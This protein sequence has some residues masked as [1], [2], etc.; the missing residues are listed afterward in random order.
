MSKKVGWNWIP[1]TASLEFFDEF[2]LEHLIK[3]TRGPRRKISDFKVTNCVGNLNLN[4][5]MVS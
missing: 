5:I 3:G 1:T 4:Q 2:I